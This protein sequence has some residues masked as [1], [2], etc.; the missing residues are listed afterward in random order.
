MCGCWLGEALELDDWLSACPRLSN[1]LFPA[2]SFPWLIMRC[3]SAQDWMQ[4]SGLIKQ[5]QHCRD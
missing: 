3:A 4:G 1:F 2:V 5:A